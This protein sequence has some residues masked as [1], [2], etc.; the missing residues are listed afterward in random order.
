MRRTSSLKPRR[1]GVKAAP[2]AKGWRA[3]FLT[4]HEKVAKLTPYEKAYMAFVR[5]LPCCCA[6]MGGCR[7]KT[8]ASHVATGPDQKGWAMKVP[9]DQ[10]IPHCNFHHRAFDGRHGNT[11]NPFRGWTKPQRYAIATEWCRLTIYATIPEDREHA[12]ALERWGLGRAVEHGVSEAWHWE[13]G[14]S[15]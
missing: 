8:Q 6:H 9:T 15:T 12:E 5:S 2:K 7:G 3:D 14:S 4:P 1:W 13:P 11:G 10:V